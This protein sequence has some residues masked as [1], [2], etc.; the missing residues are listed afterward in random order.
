MSDTKVLPRRLSFSK[1]CSILVGYLN[2]GAERDYVGVSDVANKTDV[3]LHN[4]SRNNNFFKSWGFIEEHEKE[5][6]K[7]KLTPQAAEFV[8][9]YRIDPNRDLTKQLLRR[10]LEREDLITR[11]I[12]RIKRDKMDRRS[13]LVELPAM[14]GDL[15]ADKVGLKAFVDMLAYAFQ[16]DEILAG[17]KAPSVKKRAKP[18]ERTKK[19]LVTKVAEIP[20]AGLNFSVNL[21]ISPEISPAKLKEYIKAILR[22]YDEYKQEKV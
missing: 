8:S 7:Y 17:A 13:L 6:G 16:L 5:P 4:I 22:A 9:A 11:L 19:R 15:R 18:S 14:L 3:T 12:E 20:S 21:T 2:A 10:I 1:I